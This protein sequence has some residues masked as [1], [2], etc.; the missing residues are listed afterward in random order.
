MA[1]RK[2]KQS[3]NIV[4]V[5]FMG[6]GKSVVGRALARKIGR[7]F[8]DTDEM[9]VADGPSI[10]EIF[11]KE[12]ESG[13][14]AREKSA[15]AKA[16]R[17]SGYV[18]ATGGG[19]LLDPQNAKELKRS[20]RVIYLRVAPDELARRLE[21]S[22][23]VRPLV[24]EARRAGSPNGRLRDWVVNRLA[25]RGP[26]YE[27]AA[28]SVV[29]CDGLT[30]A[31]IVRDI[32]EL[33]GATAAE[34]RPKR[35]R[36]DVGA[37]Y[38]VHVGDG[39]LPRAA[40]LVKLSRSTE[41]ACIVS[42]PR[43]RKLWGAPL[44]EALTRRDLRVAW[45]TFP[46]GESRKTLETSAKILGSLGKAGFHRGDVLYAFGGGVV[47][48]VTG[49][50]ASIY[51]RGLSYVQVPTTL[52]AMVDASIGGK[53]G[54]NLPQGKNLVGTFHQPLGVIADIDV[55]STLPDRELRGGLAEV[56]KYAF[57]AD[58]PL[59]RIVLTKQSEILAR[60]PVLEN[61]VARCAKTKAEIVAADEREQ[62]LRAIL[63]Y[64]HTLGH[65]LESLSVQRTSTAAVPKLH[66]G[67]AISIGM[68]Y[69]AAVG[70]LLGLSDLVEDHRRTLEAVGLPTTVTGLR[71]SEIERRM[72]IDK[73]YD[74]GVRLVLLKEPGTPI[75]R[76]VDSKVLKKAYESV[77][78]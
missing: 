23:F 5:G 29:D 22:G 56:V 10:A 35:V 57:I 4:L 75:V 49:Y 33:V 36:V 55:L 70:R 62:G 76:K 54:V 78:A 48:D 51:A 26:V 72:R 2:P 53:T 34:R 24:N 3:E 58:P 37:P 7:S 25:E 21:K 68:V 74:R 1:A 67:E 19:A 45:Y 43:L 13:F 42:H 60:G 66:H 15:V 41:N 28:D 44:E 64:G 59:S 63:N 52:L 38:S 11:E 14:R 61:I 12:G 17:S 65:A 16:A 9:V 31:Q 73:K 39:L 77:A 50:V 47:G 27:A 20:G 6:S 71:W 18:I 8:V 46:E 32:T 40:E 30:P 69:A